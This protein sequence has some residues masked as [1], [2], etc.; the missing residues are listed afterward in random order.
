MLDHVFDFYL[1]QEDLHIFFQKYEIM[2]RVFSFVMRVIIAKDTDNIGSINKI[3][4][5]KVCG[6]SVTQVM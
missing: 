5:L 1:R 3:C 2:L 4:L 6:N